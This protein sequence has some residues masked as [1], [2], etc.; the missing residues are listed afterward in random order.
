MHYDD[1]NDTLSKLEAGKGITLSMV[2]CNISTR[3]SHTKSWRMQTYIKI[4]EEK[5]IVFSNDVFTLFPLLYMYVFFSKFY[6][7]LTT[8]YHI[9]HV[10]T[11][12]FLAPPCSGSDGGVCLSPLELEA[13][14]GG[15]CRGVLEVEA[16]ALNTSALSVYFVLPT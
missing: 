9:P 7:S 15:C 6:L 11:L 14:A 12:V 5:R 13:A 3:A 10:C 1:A 4:D 2:A 16:R 8:F